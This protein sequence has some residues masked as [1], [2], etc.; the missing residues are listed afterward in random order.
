MDAALEIP[1]LDREALKERT[2]RLCQSCHGR[3]IRLLRLHA[4]FHAIYLG[5]ALTEIAGITLFFPFFMRSSAIAFSLALLFLTA[6]SYFVVRLYLQAK[7]PEQMESLMHLYIESCKGLMRYQEGIADHHLQLANSVCKLSAEL[8]GVE[9]DLYG[10][11]PKVSTWM[12]WRDVLAMRELLLFYA[13]EEYL[14]LVKCE[15]TRLEIHAALANAYVML[16]GLYLDPNE[17]KASEEMQSRFEAAAER[18]IE[19]FNILSAYAPN[20]TWVHTQLAYSYH[21][22]N[23]PMEEIRE[24]EMILRLDPH[25]L[26]TMFKLGMRYFQQGMNA[27]G[28]QIY[29]ELKRRRYERVDELLRFYGGTLPTPFASLS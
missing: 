17:E 8:E 29:E 24:Y 1:R 25:D 12:H 18:A 28:L 19:E 3:F 4:L 22:L 27:K 2:Y 9:V 14:K 21:D 7:K 16:S 15:P 10:R 5:I 6:F 11:L 23:M 26:A 13:I 20:D